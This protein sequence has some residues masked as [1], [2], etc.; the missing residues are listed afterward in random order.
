M[1]R[2]L[3]VLSLS[4]LASVPV[5]GCDP[6]PAAGTDAGS[7]VGALADA[8]TDAPAPA[9]VAHDPS[10]QD[11]QIAELLLYDTAADPGLVTEE[12]TTAGEFTTHID[13][14][15]MP[16]GAMGTTPTRSYVYARFT[17]AG[18]EQVL[19]S[20]EDA[21]VSTDWDIAFRRF[22]VRLNSGVSGPGCVA[23]ARVPGDPAFEAVTEVP[24]G[25]SLYEEEYYTEA[26]PGACTIV[27]D[28][29]GL[30]G[31]PDAVLAGY[32]RY[33]TSMCLS[34]SGF[35]YVVRTGSGRHV[36]L[37]VLS[38]YSPANQVICDGGGTPAP[39]SGSANFR[40]RWAFLD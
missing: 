11:T 37:Q 17:D 19:V 9:C 21:F 18:L 29:S 24:A 25:L 15:A 30:P 26:S 23:G 10:C 7:D 34:M 8:G 5:A 6:A 14:T 4:A 12:G 16:G 20:D 35:V 39:P 38:Y 40:V 33:S 27:G 13:A 2:R 22:V 1:D 28:G 32:W 36:K 31:S 3:W